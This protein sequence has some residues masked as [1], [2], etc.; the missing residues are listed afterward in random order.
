MSRLLWYWTLKVVSISLGLSAGVTDY[1]I[2]GVGNIKRTPQ[3]DTLLVLFC[4]AISNL[5][6]G[7]LVIEKWKSLAEGS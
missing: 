6:S 4:T 2:P 5:V 7:Y 3:E 1:L